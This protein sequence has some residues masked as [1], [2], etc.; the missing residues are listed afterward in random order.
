[1]VNYNLLKECLKKF[2]GKNLVISTVGHIS[3]VMGLEHCSVMEFAGSKT[4]IN[5]CNFNNMMDSGDC[6]SIVLNE[7]D[8]MNF[9]IIE[10]YDNAEVKIDF[11]NG[12]SMIIVGC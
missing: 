1:M 4:G 10:L 6:V 12:Q 2:N 11:S 8:I 7:Q 3:S 5:I 9:D